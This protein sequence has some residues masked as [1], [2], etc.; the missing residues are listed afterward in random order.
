METEV[1]VVIESNTRFRFARL[2]SESSGR[3]LHTELYVERAGGEAERLHVGDRVRGRARGQSLHAP[4]FVERATPPEQLVADMES[5]LAALG[6]LGLQVPLSARQLADEQWRSREAE[7]GLMYASL[8]EALHP[9]LTFLFDWEQAHPLED[10]LLLDRLSGA[11]RPHVPGYSVE[12]LTAEQGSAAFLL[13][14]GGTRVP[15]PEAEWEHPTPRYAALVEASNALLERQG[16]PV[17]WAR[18]REDWLLAPPELARLL[19]SRSLL[20]GP[21]E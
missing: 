12:L 15:A 1:F 21:L 5:L 10:P 3:L 13:Q 17:R 4:V 6:R 19:M 9:Q 7:E 8:R 11:M 14:P 16:A 20:L 2:Q 18:L